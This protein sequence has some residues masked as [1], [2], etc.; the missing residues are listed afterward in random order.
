MVTPRRD[1]AIVGA[2]LMGR[3]HAAAA[4]RLGA[5]IV[6]IVDPD[7]TRAARLAQRCRA[8]VLRDVSSLL[9]VASR[10]AIVHVCGPLASHVSACETLLT[11]GCHVICEKPLAATAGEVERLLGLAESFSRRL[12]PVHQFA[13][14]RGVTT[15]SAHLADLAPLSRISVDICTAGADGGSATHRDDLLR[16]ALP[17]PLSV[18]RRWLPA[19]L[20]ADSAWHVHH[21]R[22]GELLASADISGSTSVIGIN[23]S[24]RPTEASAVIRGTGGTARVDFFHGYATVEGTGVSRGRKILRPFLTSTRTFATAGTNLLRRAVQ[25]EPAYP[26]LRELLRS[27]YRNCDGAGPPPMTSADILDV[28]RSRDVIVAAMTAAA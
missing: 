12:L 26:G 15:V 9:R 25:W 3:W 18:L 10:P 24:A 5:R 1:I 20:L 4:H 13:F 6:A 23:C 11:A 2:G 16:E 21:P 17:H 14:Q 7:P 8:L 28:Y 22:A 27:C 19:G